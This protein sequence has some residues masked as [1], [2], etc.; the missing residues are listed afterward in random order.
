MKVLTI[1]RSSD[2]DI[3]VNDPYVGRHH[4]QIVQHDNGS[5]SLIDLDSTNG[6]FKNG[7]RINGTMVLGSNDVVRIGNSTLDW[8]KYFPPTQKAPKPKPKPKRKSKLLPVGLGIA[9]ALFLM[10]IMAVVLSLR[11]DGNLESDIRFEGT[12]P[13]VVQVGY[14]QDGNFYHIE[15]VQGQVMVYFSDNVSHAEAVGAIKNAGGEIVAQMPSVHYYLVNTGAGEES[16]FMCKVQSKAVTEFVFPNAVSYTCAAT[17]YVMDDFITKDKFGATHGDEV[18]YTLGLCG[19]RANVKHYNENVDGVRIKW[20]EVVQDLDNILSNIDTARPPVINMSFGVPLKLAQ[21]KKYWKS[22]SDSSK[23]NYREDYINEIR[24][25]LKQIEK[26]DDKDFVIVKSSGNDGVKDFE[27]EILTPL[28]KRLSKKQ[29]SLMDRH[30][31]LVAAEDSRWNEYSNELEKGVHN[32]WVTKV[33]ISDLK[34]N[35]RDIHG[36]SFSAPRASCFIAS[37]SD[38]FDL[39]PTEVLQYVRKVTEDAPNH[40]LTQELLEKAIEADKK[41][42]SKE[43]LEGEV[44]IDGILKMHLLDNDW[45][46]NVIS[47]YRETDCVN[48]SVAFVVNSEK[49]INVLPYLE[50]GDAD[51]IDDEHQSSFMVLP[52]FKYNGR[53]FADKYAN[54]RVQATGTLYAPG[55]GWHN[56][57]VVVMRL[58]SIKLLEEDNNKKQQD[59]PNNNQNKYQKSSKKEYKYKMS[60]NKQL[61]ESKRS[62]HIDLPNGDVINYQYRRGNDSDLRYSYGSCYYIRFTLANNES[63]CKKYCILA[64]DE[65]N[66]DRLWVGSG[67]PWDDEFL[68]IKPIDL[69][70]YSESN[71]RFNAKSDNVF[72]IISQY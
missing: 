70:I 1:G 57:T 38:S 26:Y 11:Q 64:K 30:V 56:A 3:V 20:S 59:S 37:A 29:R 5:F 17:P 50:E 52:E 36:T 61:F 35:G 4:C 45:N 43:T 41:N 31:I 6:T 12:Y 47:Q 33:D 55:G 27:K 39:M 23:F 42:N 72:V 46:D 60:C 48:N 40:I 24:L 71:Q 58:R 8:K 21:G 34:Y 28:Y 15:A 69:P 25:L 66:D 32:Q 16:A 65:T 22:A 53:E 54:K 19:S 9:A 63:I 49:S 62:G 7:Q 13:D 2:N 68:S 67:N 44:T 14:E 10:V 51:F 18:S